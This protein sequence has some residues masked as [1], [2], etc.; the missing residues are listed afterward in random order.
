MTM[1]WVLIVGLIVG[2]TLTIGV[3]YAT[4]GANDEDL[5]TEEPS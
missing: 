5:V 3:L 1:W 4:Y 2:W